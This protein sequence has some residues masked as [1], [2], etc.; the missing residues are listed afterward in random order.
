MNAKRQTRHLVTGNKRWPRI[1]FDSACLIVPMAN[2]AIAEFAFARP[3]DCSA[4]VRRAKLLCSLAEF[5][6]RERNGFS[7]RSG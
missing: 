1:A 6:Q 7:S 3:T 4:I 5:A 2:I